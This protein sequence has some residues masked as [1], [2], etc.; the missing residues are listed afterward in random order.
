ME[1][2]FFD[3]RTPLITANKFAET[4]HNLWSKIMPLVLGAICEAGMNWMP[5]LF[6]QNLFGFGILIGTGLGTWLKLRFSQPVD[7]TCHQQSE[8]ARR[9]APGA[10]SLR[11]CWS[12]RCR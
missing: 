9:C 5:G 11:R 6:G 10:R 8:T 12:S 4:Q 2:K 1:R 7:P 3:T